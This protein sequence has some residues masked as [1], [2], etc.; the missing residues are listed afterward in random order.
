MDTAIALHFM[1]P[2]ARI[3]GLFYAYCACGRFISEGEATPDR[4]KATTCAFEAAEARA[5]STWKAYD[6]AR[7]IAGGESRDGARLAGAK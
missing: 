7:R 4:A 3:L 1:E 2:P 6:R 5:A